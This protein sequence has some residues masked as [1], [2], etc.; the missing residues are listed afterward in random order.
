MQCHH[1][2]SVTCRSHYLHMLHDVR[3]G[4]KHNKLQP[5]TVADLYFSVALKLIG[6]MEGWTCLLCR[7]TFTVSELKTSKLQ[8][9]L[10]FFIVTSWTLGLAASAPTGTQLPITEDDVQQ[11]VNTHNLFRCLADLPDSNMQT[12]VSKNNLHVYLKLSCVQLALT[13]HA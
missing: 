11:I 7:R 2:M 1:C 12:I 6:T 5:L 3:H 8:S 13:S 9:V 10:P 4:M